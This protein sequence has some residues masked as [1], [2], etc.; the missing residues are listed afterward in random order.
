M[1][2][3]SQSNFLAMAAGAAVASERTTGVP[4]AFTLSQ[5]IFESGWGSAMPGNN[6]FG[7]KAD[8]HGSG[9]HYSVTKEFLNGTWRTMSLTFES[10][11]TLADCFNDH[12]RL[13]CQGPYLA[14]W[15]QYKLD[16]LIEP[17][18]RGIAAHYA[19][20]PTYASKMIAESQ[21]GIVTNAIAAARLS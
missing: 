3:Q 13:I 12:G 10:Y 2:T 15:N 11:S 18:I 8:G 17:Y 19:T 21:S 16:H 20:D 5:A 4:A 14:A 9:T 7:I 1:L 6:C